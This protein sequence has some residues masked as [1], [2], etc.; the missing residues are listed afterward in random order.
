MQT[1]EKLK[2]PERVH[3]ITDYMIERTDYSNWDNIWYVSSVYKNH[4]CPTKSLF[5][6][7]KTSFK[8][9]G[10]Q[11]EKKFIFSHG[12]GEAKVET[13]DNKLYGHNK[14][15]IT[16]MFDDKSLDNTTTK[17]AQYHEEITNKDEEGYCHDETESMV[18]KQNKYLDA[19]F[20]SINPKEECSLIKGLEDLN[21]DT[22]EVQD[23]LDEDYISMNGTLYAIKE[24]LRKRFLDMIK[25]FYLVYL[26]QD[27]L[28][29]LPPVIGN[30]EIDL[31]GL[32]KMIDSTGGYLSVTFGN[33]WKEV[34]VSI[35]GLTETHEDE[36]K[37]CYKRTIEMVKCYYDTTMKP[38]FR[39]ELVKTKMVEGGRDYAKKENPQGCDGLEVGIEKHMSRK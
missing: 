38:W 24:V 12:V 31:L 3:V 20:D 23:Y 4:M 17:G 27:V 8:S 25:W 9:E 18:T 26:N 2:Y 19:Y 14:C 33:K 11:H 16:Y 10:T 13:K 29:P 36:L 21:W 5:K 35:H 7:L 1:Q 30:V 37:S 15:S 32:Y 34:V 6:R 22:N 39:E 28:E